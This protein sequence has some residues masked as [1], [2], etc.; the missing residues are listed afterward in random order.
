MKL[1]FSVQVF[2]FEYLSKI[3]FCSRI[4][5]FSAQRFLHMQF[6]CPLNSASG[7]VFTCFRL[8][9]FF[10]AVLCVSPA[11]NQYKTKIIS[12]THR[13]DFTLNY[14]KVCKLFTI[15]FFILITN[16]KNSATQFINYLFYRIFQLSNPS[17]CMRVMYCI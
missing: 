12:H 9:C 10:C 1:V 15:S 5:I 7:F 8:L 17:L 14:S 16:K 3:I 6:N 2:N 4:S 13:Y 11:W